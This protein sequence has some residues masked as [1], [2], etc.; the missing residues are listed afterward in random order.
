MCTTELGRAAKLAPEFQKRGVKMIALSCNDVDMHC[1]WVKDIEAYA[2]LTATEFPYPII[3]DTDRKLATQL[4]MI[5]PDEKDKSGMPLTA[6]AVFIIGPDK[7]VK[8]SILYPAS[9]GRNFE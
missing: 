4:G 5:D 8:L 1:N 7:K 2:G 3:D 6:R 9:T